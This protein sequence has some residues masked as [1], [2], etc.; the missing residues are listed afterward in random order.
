MFKQRDILIVLALVLSAFSVSVRADYYY[1]PYYQRQQAQPIISL[2]LDP[3][4]GL[5]SDLRIAAREGRTDQIVRLLKCGAKVDGVSEEG[6]SALMYASRD[7]NVQAGKLLLSRS[8]MT[9]LRDKNGKT[10]LMYAAIASCS[11]M[12]SL[13]VR[14]PGSSVHARDKSGRTALDY[15]REGAELYVQGPPVDSVRLLEKVSRHSMKRLKHLAVND[16]TPLM[17]KSSL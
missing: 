9:G 5:N 13:L 3:Q 14:K 17:K 7:C 12:V 10:A 6:E 1:H 2:T 16:K 15:A 8:A 11:P 4:E